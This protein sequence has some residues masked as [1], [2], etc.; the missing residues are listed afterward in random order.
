[1]VSLEEQ[2]PRGTRL[3]RRPTRDERED[4][5]PELRDEDGRVVALVEMIPVDSLN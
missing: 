2:I 3:L 5:L 1:M 4:D